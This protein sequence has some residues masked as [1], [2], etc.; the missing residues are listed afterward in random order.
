MLMAVENNTKFNFYRKHSS[1]TVYL[2]DDGI[3]KVVYEDNL[4]LGPEDFE[5]VVA[6]YVEAGKGELLR[7]LA[8]FPKHTNLSIEGR[9]YIQ[10]R[11]IPAIAEAVI[12]TTLGQRLLF[13]FYQKFRAV[14]YPIKG[15]KTE[16][17][18]LQWLNEYA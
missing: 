3:M 8:V 2:S 7:I 13:K 5:P 10:E 17:E 6:D 16:A 11:E 12:F 1:S 14:E 9:K 18:G 15:F 4:V